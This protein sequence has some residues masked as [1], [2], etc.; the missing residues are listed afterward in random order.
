MSK[1][2]PL[3]LCFISE[4]HKTKNRPLDG[5]TRV[6]SNDRFK[7]Y[8]TKDFPYRGLFH[9]ILLTALD[10]DACGQRLGVGAHA[11]AGEVVDVG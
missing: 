6:S 1:N 9:N 7:D 11:T 5:N 4:S 10:V 2:A 3:H 8:L